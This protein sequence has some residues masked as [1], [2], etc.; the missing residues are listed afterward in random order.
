MLQ[1]QIIGFVFSF[2]STLFLVPIVKSLGLQFNLVDK[3][4]KR[5]QHKINIVRLGGVAIFCG[6]Y[7]SIFLSLSAGFINFESLNLFWPVIFCAPLFFL[8]G[9]FDDITSLSPFLRLMLQFTMAIF[10]WTKGIQ[11]ESFQIHSLFLLL[12]FLMMEVF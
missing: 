11:I 12:Y 10:A 8:I 7:F 4:G 5:K 3:P 1:D 2:L 9:L 6:F